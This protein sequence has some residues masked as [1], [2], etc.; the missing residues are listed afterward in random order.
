MNVVHP[1]CCGLDVHKKLV[2]A[3]LLTRDA[4]GEQ[5]KEIR[6]FKTMTADLLSMGD[7]LKAAGCTT[8]AMES[9]GVFWK[10]IYNLLEGQFELLVVNAQHIK[11]VPGRKTDV[12]D[13]EWIAD[14]LQHGLLKG[15]F[16]PSP[17]QR[18]WRELTRYRTSLVEERAR[19]VNR[20]QKVL[21]DTNIKLSSVATDLTG[22]SARA[23]LE[24]LVAGQ[25]DPKLLAELAR[26]RMR[27]KQA[28]LEQA[29][30]GRVT[31]HHR[32]LLSQLLAHIDY[33]DEAIAQVS[34]EIAERMRPYDAK[35]NRMDTIVGINRRTG[36]V[37]L[38]ELGADL[39]RFPSDKHVAS[40]TGLCPGNHESG[41][42]RLSGATRKG[43]PAV[44]RVLVEAAH[45]AA[46]TKH[47]YLSA[48]YHRLARRL[49]K[50]KA[51]IAVA[52]SLLVIVYHVLTEDQDYQELGG[53]YFD[54]R[55]RQAVQRRLVQRLEQLGYRVTLET[56]GP[57]A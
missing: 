28:L 30:V 6:S 52:H 41:G 39:T 32:F 53:N 47:T 31:A 48:Q 16:I 33:L 56:T 13:A 57:A 21:E 45:A 43:N 10:P 50:K 40:W 18:E 5:H 49:G 1:R 15:S 35:I 2:V 42:K 27:G 23:M 38:A 19:Q 12:K 3:C 17:E 8:V 14:L 29:L 20:L 9:T 55:D 54:E 36:E 25:T 44:R 4:Q 24:A 34:Q 51:L 46:H 22:K 26:G 37:L 11:A 7:W